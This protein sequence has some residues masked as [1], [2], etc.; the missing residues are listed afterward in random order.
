VPPTAVNGVDEGRGSEGIGAVVEGVDAMAHG[1][2]EVLV[3]TKVGGGG[4]ADFAKGVVASGLGPGVG[5]EVGEEPVGGATVNVNGTTE[6]SL[7]EDDFLVGSGPVLRPF[8]K[9]FQLAVAEEFESFDVDGF[10]VVLGIVD[11]VRARS[12]F[13]DGAFGTGFE[14]PVF[15]DGEGDSGVGEVG[16]V[17]GDVTLD[18][19]GVDGVGKVPGL[20]ALDH[21]DVCGRVK[22]SAAGAG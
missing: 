15:E 12:H 21:V 16:E 8:V 19:L 13:R 17:D 10:A 22:I 7:A 20:L 2:R 6:G 18:G 9:E 14:F 1:D 4:A 11:V 3:A 5:I